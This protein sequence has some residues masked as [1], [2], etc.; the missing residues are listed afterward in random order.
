MALDQQACGIVDA[1]SDFQVKIMEAINGRFAALRRLANLLEAAGDLTGFIPDI[2]L[3]I[4]ISHIDARLYDDLRTNCPFLN[5]PP[6]TQS[7]DQ[8][9]GELRAQVNA[10]YGRLL[11]QVKLHPFAIMGRLQQKL[12]DFQTRINAG[13]LLGSDFLRCLQSV[14]AA[15][16]AVEGTGGGRFNRSPDNIIKTSTTFYANMVT[17]QGQLLSGAAQAK[18]VDVQK[19]Q[20]GIQ[21]LIKT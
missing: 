4:P 9:L 12:N 7:A 13:A 10:A 21:N 18:V 14:C 3:L 5:L 2:S 19:V 17:Q 6:I 20:A 15:G 16:Q 11:G 1:L 8:F